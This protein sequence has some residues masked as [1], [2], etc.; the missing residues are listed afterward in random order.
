MEG[1]LTPEEK[2]ILRYVCRYLK[3]Y[4]LK[5]GLLESEIMDSYDGLDLSDIDVSEWTHFANNYRVEVPQ[6]LF[7]ILEK[8]LPVAQE[9]YNRIEID[10]N[11]ND[12]NYAR[13]E[14]DIDADSEEISAYYWYTYYDTDDGS[15]YTFSEDD[16]SVKNVLDIISELDDTVPIMELRYNGSGDSG[17]VESDFENGQNVPTSV[18]DFCYRILEE[19]CGGWEINEGSQGTFYFDLETREIT[20]EHQNNTE[21]SSTETLFEEKFGK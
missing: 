14:I 18:D 7:P 13:F 8:I 10:T 11:G 16:E 21:E 2:K 19:E 9:S 12:I 17:Y 3:S 4:R 6:E 1:I 5:S 15:S 20:L